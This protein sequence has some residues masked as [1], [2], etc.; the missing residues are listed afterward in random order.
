MEIFSNLALGF[1][2]A[3]TLS[4]L[5]YCLMGMIFATILVMAALAM[6]VVMLPTLRKKREEAFVED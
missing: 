5:M 4:N 1:D 3:F 6:A 2:T